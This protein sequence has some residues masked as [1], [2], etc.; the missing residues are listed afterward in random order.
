MDDLDIKQRGSD[1]RID[2]DGY[3]GGEIWLLDFDKD[4]LDDEDFIFYKDRDDDRDDD[5]DDRDDDRDDDDDDTGTPDIVR[6]LGGDP[7]DDIYYGTSGDNSKNTGAGDDVLYGGPG[8]DVLRGGDGVDSYEGGPGS[9]TIIVDIDDI[10]GKKMEGSERARRKRGRCDR[11]RAE[12]QR[13]GEQRYPV[14]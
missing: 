6:P 12:P 4:D 10:L 5:D 2:L 11:W 8:D 1:T 13:Q 7:N 9:D 14:I 3:D